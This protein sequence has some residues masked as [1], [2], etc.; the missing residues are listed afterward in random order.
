[1]PTTLKACYD[2][3]K[4][5]EFPCLLTG[6]GDFLSLMAKICCESRTHNLVLLCGKGS[7]EERAEELRD[8]LQ[9]VNTLPLV[10]SS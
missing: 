1:M 8:Y 3:V 2:S 7:F 4:R 5:V 10:S 9:V 6:Y